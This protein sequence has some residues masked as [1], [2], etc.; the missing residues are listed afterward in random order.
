MQKDAQ[1][2]QAKQDKDRER[3]RMARESKG[4]SNS[5]PEGQAVTFKEPVI[6]LHPHLGRY[7]KPHQ[8][9]GIQFMWRELI[10]ANNQQ[11][12]LLAH[13]MGLGKSMQV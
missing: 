6:Y 2:R 7:V 8:L 5:D 11:G 9:T 1:E 4:L 13:T 12:C 10:E 3:L